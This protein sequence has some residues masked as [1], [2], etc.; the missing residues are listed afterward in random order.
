MKTILY[1]AAIFLFFI[2]L[3]V[4]FSN[5]NYTISNDAFIGIMASFIGAAATIIVG[6]QIYNSIEAKRLI[7]D[8]RSEQKNIEIKHRDICKQ[9]GSIESKMEEWS[10]K[11]EEMKNTS[12]VLKLQIERMYSNIDFIQAFA[13]QDDYPW[14]AFSTCLN[15]LYQAMESKNNE[16]VEPCLH[17]LYTIVRI[18][19][20]N[21]NY[22]K[23]K[24]MQNVE[25]SLIENIDKIKIHP[26]YERISTLFDILGLEIKELIKKRLEN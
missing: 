12:D 17:L 10:R 23:C 7:S 25:K 11:Y 21:D 24:L 15:S 4:I 26:E 16:V 22:K 19:K 13:A 5:A 6:A 14:D 2:G 1:F 9:I 20:K 3:I 18:L 8:A